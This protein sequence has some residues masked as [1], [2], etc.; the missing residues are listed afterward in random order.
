[1]LLAHAGRSSSPDSHVH[2]RSAITDAKVNW[3]RL[4]AT[5]AELLEEI[6]ARVPLRGVPDLA[7]Q[8]DGATAWEHHPGKWAIRTNADR[9]PEVRDGALPIRALVVDR[10]ENDPVGEVVVWVMNGRLSGFE[11]LRFTSSAPTGL[12]LPAAI[13]V[14]IRA[15]AWTSDGIDWRDE[16]FDDDLAKAWLVDTHQQVDNSDVSQRVWELTHE[17]LDPARGW[18]LVKRMIQLARGQELWH[19]GGGPL[20]SIVSNHLALIEDELVML[21]RTNPRFRRAFEGQMSTALAQ[22]QEKVGRGYWGAVAPSELLDRLLEVAEL[23]AAPSEEQVAWIRGAK[24]PVDELVLQYMDIV[25]GWI[26]RLQAENVL[27]PNAEKV[28]SKLSSVIAG[29]PPE[30]GLWTEDALVLDPRWSAVRSAAR[31]VVAE[32]I[33]KDQG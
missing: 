24:V 9:I 1:M 33:A 23:L 13:R 16:S 7:K 32:L 28:L 17:D 4:D 31:D 20:G 26:P 3:A 5:A 6:L 19:V 27:L 22:F 30:E 8:L 29:L 2:T 25:P 14:R 10:D 18:R 21:Y 15:H 12:P 11:C